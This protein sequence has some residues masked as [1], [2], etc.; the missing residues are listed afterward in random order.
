[1]KTPDEEQQFVRPADKPLG[2][3]IVQ[4]PPPLVPRFQGEHRGNTENLS[5]D[6]RGEV[7]AAIQ[8]KP[9]LPFMIQDKYQRR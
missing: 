5:K 7:V 9:N 6:P 1:V 3:A 8:H 2:S 4:R